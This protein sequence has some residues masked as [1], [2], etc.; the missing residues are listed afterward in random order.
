MEGIANLLFDLFFMGVLDIGVAGAGFGTACA[1]VLRC[2]ATVIYM[3]RCTDMYKSSK[4]K[5][6]MREV[7][8]LLEVGVPDST[9]GLMLALQSYLIMKIILIAFG[10]P[11]GV[12][13]GVTSLCFSIANVLVSGVSASVR[14]S[15]ALYGRDGGIRP[16]G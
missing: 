1:N 6:S 12:I 13:K 7:A 15:C 14:P 9:N 10:T 2:S 3:I 16:T 8:K 4:K 5:V 11:G